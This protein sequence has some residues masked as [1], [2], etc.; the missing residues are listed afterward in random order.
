MPRTRFT[1]R[2]LA[3]VAAGVALLTLLS[4]TQRSQR[5]PAGAASGGK[6]RRRN[7]IKI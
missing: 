2:E 3:A 4:G 7:E 1:H 6:L 5:R